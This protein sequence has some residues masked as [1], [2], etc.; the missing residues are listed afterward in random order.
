MPINNRYSI[1]D[2]MTTAYANTATT[3]R[4]LMI[5]YTLFAGVN[6]TPEIAEQLSALLH[7]KP[8]MVNIIPFNAVAEREF[9]APSNNTVHRF[10]DILKQNGIHTRIRRERGA[11]IGSA[12]GQ[13][14]LNQS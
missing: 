11:D 6:D 14:R 10:A 13:L 9:T 2:V 1:A 5:E 8:V 3:G 4:Q 12:C 7:D